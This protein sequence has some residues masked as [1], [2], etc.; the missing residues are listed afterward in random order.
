MTVDM[1]PA[2]KI[3]FRLLINRQLPGEH[4]EKDL[5]GSTYLL[6]LLQAFLLD[7]EC[8]I[9]QRLHQLIVGNG[10]Q[11]IFRHPQLHRRSGI[12]KLRERTQHDRLRMNAGLHHLLQHLQSIHIRHPDI[13]DHNIRFQLKDRLQPFHT[14]P[15]FH[16]HIISAAGTGQQLPQTFPDADLIFHNQDF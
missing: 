11:K 15:G 16:D 5:L 8:N 13:R 12:L 3:G 9:L 14:V 10:L 1:I 6:R 2:F 7:L 4:R